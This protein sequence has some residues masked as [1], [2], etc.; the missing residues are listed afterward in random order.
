MLQSPVPDK[1]GVMHD[2]QEGVRIGVGDMDLQAGV[3]C[4]VI[5]PRDREFNI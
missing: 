4:F 5:K 2:L 3:G 1:W